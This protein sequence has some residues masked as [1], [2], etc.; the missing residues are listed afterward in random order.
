MKNGGLTERKM[1]NE[2]FFKT[3]KAIF[4][5]YCKLRD[6]PSAKKIA[7]RAKIS[8]ATL[9]RHHRKVAKIPE[10]YEKYLLEKYHK[11]MRG[12]VKKEAKIR[13]LYFRALVFM[14]NNKDII[15]AL[16]Q[17][18]RKEIIKN[19]ADRLKDRVVNE[20]KIGGDLSKMFSIYKNEIVGV[21]EDWAEQDFSEKKLNK[22]LDDIVYLTQTARQRL[23][24]LK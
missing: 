1:A 22:T 7:Q 19:M 20:W 16:F 13:I 15:L 14:M 6:Y 3:E 24:P 9:Y 4:I 17:E 5:A 23:L 8:R 10:D 12:F 21:I 11:T 18:G 2:R